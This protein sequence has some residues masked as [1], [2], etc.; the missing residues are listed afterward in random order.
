MQE[1]AER[2]SLSPPRGK[3][4]KVSLS[5][6][7]LL[8]AAPVFAQNQPNIT[9]TPP[10][11]GPDGSRF[12]V[13]TESRQHPTGQPAAGKA[14]VYFLEDDDNFNSVPKPTTRMSV[15]GSWAGATH[16]NSYFY[17]SVDPGEHHLCAVWQSAV[18][19]SSG[20]QSALAHFTADSGGVYY[21]R[22]E[23]SWGVSGVPSVTMRAVSADEG[24]RLVSRFALSTS[25]PKK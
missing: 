5:I 16:G 8:C 7:V 9:S 11:C 14:L 21:F 3:N 4:V 1:Q 25:T 15:D 19:F 12:N 24:Q 10:V 23:N 2:S 22:V 17:V 18:D 20:R 6:L 13:K